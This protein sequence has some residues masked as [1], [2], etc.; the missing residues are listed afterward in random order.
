MLGI[1]TSQG[2]LN[3]CRDLTEVQQLTPKI[4]HH[5]DFADLPDVVEAMQ[6]LVKQREIQK[7]TM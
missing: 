3:C 5:Q 6:P 1:N 2:V 7:L 4:K